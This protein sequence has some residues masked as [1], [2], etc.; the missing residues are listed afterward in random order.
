MGYSFQ[1]VLLVFVLVCAVMAEAFWSSFDN[2]KDFSRSF[3]KSILAGSCFV[4]YAG[5]DYLVIRWH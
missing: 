2:D 4:I 1:A 3:L 5:I